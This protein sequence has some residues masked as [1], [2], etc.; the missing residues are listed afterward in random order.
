MSRRYI[1]SQV[2][3]TVFQCLLY[4][5]LFLSFFLLLSI[6][7]PQIINLSRTAATTMA[8]FAIVLVI[9]TYV[10]GGYQL[11]IKKARSVFS[12]VLIAVVFADVFTYL[13]LEIMNVNPAKNH[14][15]ILFGEDF[16]LFCSA[17]ILQVGL[18]YLF[19]WL[20]YHFYFKINPPQKCCIITS[21]QEQAQHIAEKIATFRQKY[22][23]LDVLHYECADVHQTI[24][25]HDVVFLAGI[26]DTE[27][28]ELK[29]FCYKYGKTMYLL[30][31]LEDVITSTSEQSVID[32]TLFL[33]IH[34]VEPSLVQRFV[35]RASD[36][37]I[38]VLGLVIT[39]PIM[40]IAALLI[41]LSHNGP[42]F[43]RQKRATIGGR[44]F[45]IIKFRTM[46][47]NACDTVGQSACENDERIT[48]VGRVLRKYRIDELPQLFN[49]LVGDMSIVGPR[50]EMLEN[51]NRYTGELPEFAYRLRAKAGLT[52]MAQIY[53]KY[54]TSPKDKLILDLTYIEQ[55]SIW[56]DI[57]LILRTIL[58]L[59]TPDESTEAFDKSGKEGKHGK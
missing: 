7:N 55:Y 47:R 10:Y 56:L 17:L 15:L 45:T 30:A 12:S 23:L 40:L 19:V 9:L 11:G 41:F 18:I 35:K 8:T 20:G 51:V 5:T 29:S 31:E 22:R 28:A 52:G 54:N 32:D 44:V 49:V 6:T 50:P 3:K 39:S 36:I 37:I 57:K 4:V 21:S 16:W 33:C 34:R 14:R 59:L 42:I 38:S 25:N 53:G 2:V 26:P 48:K 13:Q 24:L 58:V 27:E 43:F 1:L 46:Y